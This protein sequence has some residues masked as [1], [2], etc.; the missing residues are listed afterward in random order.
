M[1]QF[2]ILMLI[3]FTSTVYS[4]NGVFENQRGINSKD[5][6]T[7]P[8]I[9]ADGNS[10]FFNSCKKGNNR[11]WRTA[12]YANENRFDYDIYSAEKNNADWRNP[13]NLGRKINS[14]MDDAVVSISPD[15]Q[16]VYFLSFKKNWEYDGGPYYK[17]EL[18]G[19][20]WTNIQGLGGGITEFFTRPDGGVW[21]SGASISPDGKEFYFAT[22]VATQHGTFDIWVAYYREGKWSYPE[23]LGNTINFSAKYNAS[24]YMA[25]D[26]KT[27][28]F[29]STG[30]GGFGDNDLYFSVKRFNG[31]SKPLNL[32]RAINTNESEKSLSIPASGNSV[33]LVSSRKGTLGSSDI[34]KSD[35]P[36]EIR[37]STV[38][39]VK[40][41]IFDI[42]T[43][44]P[45]EAN[46][47]IQDL[48]SANE[49]YSVWSNSETGQYSLVLQSGRNY[50]VSVDKEGYFFFEDNF[51]I[52]L[53]TVY[54]QLEKDYG[55]TPVD[56][57]EVIIMNNIFFDFD[58]STLQ[59]ESKSTLDRTVK[60]L[61]TYPS[62]VLEVRGHTDNRGTAEYNDNLSR[63]RALAVKTALEARGIDPSRL[64]AVG[65]GFQNPIADNETEEGRAQNRRTEFKIL[66]K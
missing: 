40:G 32:G 15:G 63:N 18:R 20:E 58:K 50:G 57:N 7:T 14:P 27:L 19:N 43:D 53:S 48:S 12:N 44:E 23:N 35:L 61:N 66:A 11:S 55:L 41:K 6:D 24:P 31:W 28:F 45:L 39:L 16:I 52:L 47:I 64:E 4:Q 34:W 22:S 30:H 9:T 2:V 26:G 13:K 46:I 59:A 38:T 10:I 17:T 65:F 36:V 1:R 29:S 8:I 3:S 54:N 25:F 42:K 60:F 49:L 33:Y 37:P 62:V 51:N 5:S 21:V 56:V